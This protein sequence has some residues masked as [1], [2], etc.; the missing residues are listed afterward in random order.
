MATEGTMSQDKPSPKRQYN[1]A[2]RPAKR[3]AAQPSLAP[4]GRTKRA[5][6]VPRDHT[7]LTNCSLCSGPGSLLTACSTTQ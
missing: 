5:M 7:I 3:Q 6:H 4:H 1:T 2:R